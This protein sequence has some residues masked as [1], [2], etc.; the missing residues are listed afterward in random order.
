MKNKIELDYKELDFRLTK[1]AYKLSDVA[2]KVE[3]VAFDVVKFKDGDFSHL[4]QVNKADDGN[5]YIVALYNEEEQIEKTAS[6]RNT[7]WSVLKDR[8]NIHIVYKNEP[9]AKFAASYLGIKESDLD[10]VEEYL[11]NKLATNKSLVEKLL[12]SVGKIKK[13]ELARK[14]PELF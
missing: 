9:I 4:W 5:E 7:N 12:K 13:E 1:K 11:P 14:Y 6:V 8:E 10:L 2:D 3:K